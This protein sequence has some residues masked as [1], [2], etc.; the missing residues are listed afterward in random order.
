[1]AAARTDSRGSG[2]GAKVGRGD[3]AF[4]S[5]QVSQY[6][7]EATMAHGDHGL[8]HHGLSCWSLCQWLARLGPLGLL[9]RT[10]DRQTDYILG[11][12]DD[13]SFIVGCCLGVM[14]HMAP[15]VCKNR[16]DVINSNRFISAD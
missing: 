1:M 16:M 11:I 5:T 2:G 7:K 3:G 15:F 8:S 9:A 12:M 14:R 13:R 10:R 4:L 6:K